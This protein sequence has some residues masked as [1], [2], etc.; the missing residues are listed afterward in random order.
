MAVHDYVID[1]STGAN[2]RADINN[3]LLAIV[4]NN[5]SSSEPS[6][7]KYAYMWWADTT[8]GILKIRNS[9]NDGWVELLQLDGTLT[10]EDGSASTPALAFRDDLNTGIFSPSAD[11]IS[12]STGGVK[13]LTVA[14]GKVLINTDTEGHADA[15]ELTIERTSGGY[16]GLTLRSATDQGGAIYFSDATSGAGEYDGQIL[17]SQANRIMSFAAAGTTR[18]TLEDGVSKFTG[19]RILLGTS[20]EGHADAD[21]LTLE[22]A[23][24]YTGITLR[25]G[26]TAGGA[27][28][29]SDATSGDGEYVGQILYSHNANTMTLSANG[30]PALELLSNRNVEV[31]DG[32]L[33]I[34]TSGHGIDFAAAGGSASGSTGSVLNDYE[35]GTWTPAYNSGSASG[36]C[37]DNG[38]SYNTGGQTGLYTKIGNVVYFRFHIDPASSGLTAKTGIL[39]IN[40]L[41][42]TSANTS[43]I[44]SGAAFFMFTNAFGSATLPNAVVVQNNAYIQFYDGNGGLFRGVDLSAPQNA[45]QMAGMYYV[46]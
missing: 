29:F 22:S 44:N 12:L 36:A 16:V 26:A 7:T 34:G 3:A 2:V 39:Q 8:N 4:S 41:P 15:D 31:T 1:N 5:S 42:F 27:I 24:G 21:D 9:A 40:G 18:L 45:I 32:D 35:E 33:V 6:T 17:Y 38:I 14:S 37:F 11:Q 25:A 46:A 23:S 19:G 43:H 30:S 13:C 10:L 28:Y 20:T